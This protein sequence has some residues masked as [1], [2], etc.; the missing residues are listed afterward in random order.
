L[1]ELGL[2]TLK[3]IS[4]LLVPKHVDIINNIITAQREAK[5][6]DEVRNITISSQKEGHKYRTIISGAQHEANI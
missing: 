3:R 1:L 2:Y 4:T 6:I 5:E